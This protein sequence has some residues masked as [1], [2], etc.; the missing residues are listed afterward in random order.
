M[1]SMCAVCV[2]GTVY[3][4]FLF[5][6]T[7]DIY[8]C[9][10]CYCQKYVQYETDFVFYCQW[11]VD[12]KID[13]LNKFLVSGSFS[14]PPPLLTRDP[15]LEIHLK[16]NLSNNCYLQLVNFYICFHFFSVPSSKEY[17]WHDT[18][19]RLVTTYAGYNCF[20]THF[21]QWSGSV[22]SVLAAGL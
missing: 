17:N 6:T 3:A 13:F 19:R 9:Y 14:L 20:S 18:D 12:N 11:S 5:G 10:I 2:Y 7:Q 21:Q 15:S 4:V 22:S 8:I 1:Y 16:T